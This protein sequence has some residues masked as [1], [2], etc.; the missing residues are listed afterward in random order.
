MTVHTETF[1]NI[2]DGY[3]VTGLNIFI[4]GNNPTQIISI[5]SQIGCNNKCSFC[6]SE[7]QSL[8]RNLTAL[9]ILNLIETA[10]K[11]TKNIEISFTGEGE[12]LHNIKNINK[13]I[14]DS[15]FQSFKIAFS[16]LGSD[17]ISKI[18][19]KDIVTLQFSL[20]HANP[21]KRKEIIPK[22]DELNIIRGNLLA[23]KNAFKSININYVIIPGVNNSEE[24]FELLDKFLNGTEWNLIFNPLLEIDN[25]TISEEKE[26][27]HKPIKYYKKIGQSITENHLYKQF[28][29]QNIT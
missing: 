13:V 15:N 8:I 16:G 9:E 12:P 7:K 22:T 11:Y 20:H 27:K 1:H 26:L 18:V 24:D 23:S 2:I 28:T 10:P 6:I 29:Y 14:E 25:Y 5:P 3:K 21:I 4:D 17:L 19:R